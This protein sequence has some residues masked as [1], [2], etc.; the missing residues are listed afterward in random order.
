MSFIVIFP[1][2]PLLSRRKSEQLCQ[3]PILLRNDYYSIKFKGR[4]LHSIPSDSSPSDS[5]VWVMHSKGFVIRK[6]LV[7][8]HVTWE[9]PRI[10]SGLFVLAKG[11][12]LIHGINKCSWGRG[13][14][15]GVG[16]WAWPEILKP[17][18]DLE[19]VCLSVR[20]RVPKDPEAAGIQC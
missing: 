16:E 4:D 10:S 20:E 15:E 19:L 7:S 13:W 9:E 5:L 6:S 17:G 2:I 14:L 3:F 12:S 1:L 18:T 8:P 11:D